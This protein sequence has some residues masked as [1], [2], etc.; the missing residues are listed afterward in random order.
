MTRLLQEKL[1][2]RTLCRESLTPRDSFTSRVY[3]ASRMDLIEP[4]YRA[5]LLALNRLRNDITHNLRYLDFNLR[6]YVQ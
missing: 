4:D 5:F 6:H 2:L 1:R 3:L